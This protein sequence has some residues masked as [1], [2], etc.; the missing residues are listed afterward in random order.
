MGILCVHRCY[1]SISCDIFYNHSKA[2]QNMT[3]TVHSK[4]IKTALLC[5]EIMKYHF[6]Q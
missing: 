2:G 4:A 1:F 6:E 3:E 5:H